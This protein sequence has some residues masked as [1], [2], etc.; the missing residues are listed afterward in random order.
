MPLSCVCHVLELIC[1]HVSGPVYTLFLQAT[2]RGGGG[3]SC[4]SSQNA[5]Q[6]TEYAS[7]AYGCEIF[8]NW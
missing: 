7:A 5:L 8:V 2:R 4:F 3:L 1:R 6:S